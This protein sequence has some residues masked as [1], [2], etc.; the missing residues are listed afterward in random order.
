MGNAEFGMRISE[1]RMRS[2]EWEMRNTLRN[3]K[4]RY[5]RRFD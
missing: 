1:C 5:V 4:E 2:A 3:E